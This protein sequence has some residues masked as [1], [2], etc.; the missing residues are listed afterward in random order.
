MG[1]FPSSHVEVNS[2]SAGTFLSCSDL[3]PG[4]VMVA[5]RAKITLEMGVCRSEKKYLCKR[6][7]LC[8]ICV[9][10]IPRSLPV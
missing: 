8:R 1:S 7:G 9:L 4:S 6:V 3:G 10:D 2:G 5:F